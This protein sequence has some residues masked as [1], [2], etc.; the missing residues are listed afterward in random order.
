[1]V[2]NDINLQ[3]ELF[4]PG[5]NDPLEDLLLNAQEVDRARLAGALRGILGVDTESGRLVL[6]PGFTTLNTRQKILAYLLGRKAAHL[7][8][9][10]ENEAAT[11]KTIQAETGMP[12]GTV[13]P[14]SRELYDDHKISQ[15]AGKEYYVDHHQV[16]A[17]IEEL[18][19][20]E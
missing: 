5:Q 14:K 19:K 1:M 6:K 20:G 4:M 17:A 16:L 15:T 13:G 18:G 3:K 7:L 12:A 8:G 2:Y 9:K 10:L 11:F